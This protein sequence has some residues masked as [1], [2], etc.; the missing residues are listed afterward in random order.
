MRDDLA[1]V[2]ELDRV[3][4]TVSRLPFEADPDATFRS[5]AGTG[6]VS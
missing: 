1:G 5:L 3:E 4:V 6:E 2:G